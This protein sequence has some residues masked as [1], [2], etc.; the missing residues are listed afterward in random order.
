MPADNDQIVQL[1]TEIRNELRTS[2]ELT[3][4]LHS[5]SL[6]RYDETR[7]ASQKSLSN[8]LALVVL[9]LCAALIAAIIVGEAPWRNDPDPPEP[10]Y[11]PSL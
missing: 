2:R 4:E 5:E 6:R 10:F 9:M 7:K 1:L 11:G 8:Y 3:R